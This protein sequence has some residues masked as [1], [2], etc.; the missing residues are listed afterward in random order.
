MVFPMSTHYDLTVLS[1]G[2]GTQSAALALMSATGELPRLDAVIFADT[3]GELPETYEYAEYVKGYL[4]KADI[5][6]IVTTAGSL[7]EA[8]LSEEPTS[9]NPTPPTMV[10]SPDGTVG[11][12]GKYTCSWDF[13]RRWITRETKRLV[14]PPGVWKRAT[15]EQWVG[16]S[17]DEVQR[18]KPDPECRCGH[19]IAH[20]RFTGRRCS[21]CDCESFDAWRRNR[22]PLVELGMRREDTIAWFTGHGHPIPP[23]SA[24][25]FCPNSSNERWT[26]I[27]TKHPDLWER[28]CVLDEHIRRGGAFNR[29]GKQPLRGELFLHRSATPLRSADLRSEREILKDAGIQTLWDD[30]AMWACAGSTCMT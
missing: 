21:E 8:L 17:A 24:C 30:D 11:R 6:F 23:R 15:V 14:G 1:Y 3:H 13:K 29:R 7:E 12:V 19:T 22:W 2:G 4:D 10:R 25:F 26:E 27:K 16:M 20:H 5:P 18:C 9:A 28:A